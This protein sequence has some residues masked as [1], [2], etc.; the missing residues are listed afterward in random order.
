MLPPPPA[1]TTRV[2]TH[3]SEVTPCTPRR[4]GRNPTNLSP[5][6]T[7]RVLLKVSTN[8]PP[9]G[10]KIRHPRVNLDISH[11]PTG[12]HLL[13]GRPARTDSALH[14]LDTTGHPTIRPLGQT[15]TGPTVAGTEI[16]SSRN[17]SP[18]LICLSRVIRSLA[19]SRLPW[20]RGLMMSQQIL[21]RGSST[22]RFKG[23]RG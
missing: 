3:R 19:L 13:L 18:P 8:T 14:P 15:T 22:K 5:G 1:A 7:P 21:A 4:H 11:L 17:H 23:S 6:L 9:A 16:A 12:A 10:M 20:D 2:Q